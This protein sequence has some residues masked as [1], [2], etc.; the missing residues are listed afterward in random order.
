MFS[1]LGVLLNFQK[2]IPRQSNKHIVRVFASIF[3][4]QW[5]MTLT[6]NAQVLLI[7]CV[8]CIFLTIDVCYSGRKQN[9]YLC[10]WLST[11]FFVAQKP[12]STRR[13]ADCLTHAVFTRLNGLFQDKITVVTK[14]LAYTE[15]V[16]LHLVTRTSF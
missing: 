11:K 4:M 5:L 8:Q 3:I 6:L 13:P 12:L 16:M 2:I 9:F 7:P 14:N 10:S 15:I 1:S